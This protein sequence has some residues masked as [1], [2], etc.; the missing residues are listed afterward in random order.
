MGLEP[1]NTMRGFRR[2]LELGC[3][4][5]ET[6]LHL[7]DGEL[8]LLHDVRLDRTTNGTGGLADISLEDLRK[9]DAGKGEQVP[10]LTELLDLCDGKEVVLNLEIKGA[11][12]VG[13]MLEVLERYPLQQV[14]V[15]S[16]DWKQLRE[17]RELAADLPLAVLVDAPELV[18]DSVGIFEEL[19][20]VSWNPG[21]ALFDD[22]STKAVVDE[23]H[24]LGG[25]VYPFTVKTKEDLESVVEIGCD[26]AF[27]ND[28]IAVEQWLK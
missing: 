24:D 10:L 17:C 14:V 20:A 15:S 22:A 21:L 9:L 11:G 2:A 5:I 6:D 3:K 28:P 13:P 27:V 16:F 12:V 25:K 1:E 4:M 7:V 18:C 8:I 23:I 26:G 19:G